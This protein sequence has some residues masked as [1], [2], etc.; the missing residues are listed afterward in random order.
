MPPTDRTWHVYKKGVAPA[1]K[2][3]IHHC[4]PREPCPEPNVVF[5]LG[6]PGAGKGTMCELAQAQLGW[7]HLSTGDLLRAEME[8]GG[9]RAEAMDAL[10]SAGN[11]V[12]DEIVVTLLKD[13]ME[14]AKAAEAAAV[15]AH[16]QERLWRTRCLA[17]IIST[18]C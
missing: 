5:V 4:D 9:P 6:G 18:G 17:D 2:I 11:L 14:K 12:S 15:S 3:V 8:A 7:T 10:I 13:A 1:P 16:Q